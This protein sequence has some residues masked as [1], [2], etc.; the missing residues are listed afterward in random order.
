MRIHTSILSNKTLTGL[1]ASHRV[2]R[3]IP[4]AVCL[5]KVTVCHAVFSAARRD[6]HHGPDNKPTAERIEIFNDDGLSLDPQMGPLKE[7]DWAT[8]IF[9]ENKSGDTQWIALPPMRLEVSP[10]EPPHYAESD[11]QKELQQ[12]AKRLA[13]LAHIPYAGEDFYNRLLN[14]SPL[15]TQFK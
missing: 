8:L 2:L 12:I 7:G 15:P 13:E 5:V 11:R 6:M 10:A 4:R 3:V 1:P 9:V 14:G